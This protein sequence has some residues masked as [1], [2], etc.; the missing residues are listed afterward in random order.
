[1]VEQRKWLVCYIMF[2]VQAVCAMDDWLR[3]PFSIEI[4]PYLSVASIKD[5]LK[6][7]ISTNNYPGILKIIREKSWD[8]GEFFFLETLLN[9][10]VV[11][12]RVPREGEAESDEAGDAEFGVHAAHSLPHVQRR[13]A[14]RLLATSTAETHRVTRFIVKHNMRRLLYATV[15][16][17]YISPF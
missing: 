1:M 11:L 10:D 15:R 14:P 3:W 13:H 5:C 8:I 16:L 4:P 9:R 7:E 2:H 6:L 17:C 12:P